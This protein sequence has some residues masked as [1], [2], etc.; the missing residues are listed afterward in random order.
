MLVERPD[1]IDRGLPLAVQY[2]RHSRLAPEVWG[3]IAL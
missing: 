3:Q 1:L 2:F